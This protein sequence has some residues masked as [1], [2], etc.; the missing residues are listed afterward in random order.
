MRAICVH[1][2]YLSYPLMLRRTNQHCD[3]MEIR[4]FPAFTM[5]GGDYKSD[6]IS[7]SGHVHII[8]PGHQKQRAE[9]KG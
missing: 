7:G 2:D 4:S 1:L 8:Q 5:V 6:L 9:I 3:V